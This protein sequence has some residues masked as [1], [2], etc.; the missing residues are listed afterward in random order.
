MKIS[1]G[2]LWPGPSAG[3]FGNAPRNLH[4]FILLVIIFSSFW[5]HFF[6]ILASFWSIISWEAQRFVGFEAKNH[7]NDEKIK[8][9]EDFWWGSLARAL[10]RSFWE[11]LEESS[12]FH[13]FG[14]HFFIILVIIF[15]SFW[16][17][18]APSFPRNLRDS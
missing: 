11:C 10:G 7:K 17:S 6:I 4:F 12:F 1:G 13:H 3:V 9:N 14:H 16:P 2:V 18:F 8:K 15:S 5:H